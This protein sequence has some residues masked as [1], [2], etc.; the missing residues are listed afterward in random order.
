MTNLTVP[1]LLKSLQWPPNHIDF[2]GTK[3]W[4]K[5]ISEQPV[6]AA[7]CSLIVTDKVICARAVGQLGE[8]L[9]PQLE[10]IW[11][12]TSGF[13]QIN[14]M[15]YLGEIVNPPDEHRAIRHFNERTYVLGDE[16]SS[17]QNT[18]L[19][20]KHSFELETPRF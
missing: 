15:V 16:Y 19:R 1:D 9:E 10:V 13:P 14:R 8:K 20:K 2:K 12:I 17:F 11:D 6:E 7:T 4:A 3:R 5:V 18:G